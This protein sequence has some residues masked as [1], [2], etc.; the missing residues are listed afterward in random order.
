M[1]LHMQLGIE[2][3]KTSM[4]LHANAAQAALKVSCFV[5]AIEH[6]DKVKLCCALSANQLEV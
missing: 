2:S 1:P 4:T 5:Q 6:C 3:E